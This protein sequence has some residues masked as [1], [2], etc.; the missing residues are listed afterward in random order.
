MIKRT[1][2]N[3]FKYFELILIFVITLIFNIVCTTMTLDEIW[4]YGFAYNISTGLIPYKDFNMVITPLYPILGSLFLSILGKNIIVFHIYNSIIC[5][6]I[7]YYIKKFIPKSYY[8][9]YALVLCYSNPNYNILLLLLLY[10]LMHLETKKTNPYLIGI[11]LG[12][13]FLTK[14]NT[15]IYLCIPTIFIKDIKITL[16]RIIGFIIPN[17]FLLI[18]L[19]LTNSLYEF[20]DYTILGIGTF[21]KEIFNISPIPLIIILIITVCLLYEYIKTKNIIIIYMICFELLIFPLIDT[22]HVIIAIIPAI[23]YFI[24]KL[25]I[26]KKIIIAAFIT[27]LIIIFSINTYTIYKKQYSIPNVTNEYKYRKISPDNALAIQNISTYIKT[28]HEKLYVISRNAYLYKIEAHI[29]IN[30]YDLL[31]NGNL[32]SNGE[33][34]LIKQIENDCKNNNCTFLIDKLDINNNSEILYNQEI[35]TYIIEQYNVVDTIP[36]TN[37]IIYK[38]ITT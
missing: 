2:N 18:Y 35:I 30:K 26:N 24:N 8:I 32:G 20:I 3:K 1:I 12:L 5:T 28:V 13:T 6:T 15:G 11:V 21:A 37:I 16:K 25:N 4:N 27:T 19:L 14:Q 9:L 29:P 34:T 38:N 23:G 17:L 33:E 10:T 7:F 36:N 31:N 22:Y